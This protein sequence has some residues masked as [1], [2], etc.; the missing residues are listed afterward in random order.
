MDAIIPTIE[1][2]F[3]K[4]KNCIIEIKEKTDIKR[5]NLSIFIFDRFFKL[6]KKDINKKIKKTSANLKNILLSS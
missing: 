6:Y 3:L 1:I 4:N 2:L 5:S